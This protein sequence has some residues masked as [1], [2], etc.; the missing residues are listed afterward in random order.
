MT[1]IS[2]PKDLDPKVKFSVTLG[3]N[4]I[5]LDG[6][7]RMMMETDTP[8][9]KNLYRLFRKHYAKWRILPELSSEKQREYA[10]FDALEEGGATLIDHGKINETMD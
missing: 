5:N 9:A 6:A 3:E 1:D 4:I 8:Q 7:I 10:L 2:P